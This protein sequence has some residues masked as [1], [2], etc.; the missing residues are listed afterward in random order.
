MYFL[1]QGSDKWNIKGEE[2]GVWDGKDDKKYRGIGNIL[3]LFF[4]LKCAVDLLHR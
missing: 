2:S 1:K 3:V 4:F